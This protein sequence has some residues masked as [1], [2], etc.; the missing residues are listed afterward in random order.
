MFNVRI[1]KYVIVV[2]ALFV[3]FTLFA[4]NNAELLETKIENLNFKDAT[5]STIIESISNLTG[6]NI[7]LANES[8]KSSGSEDG[9]GVS[10]KRISVRL[11][12]I[13]VENAVSLVAKASG[14]TYN[15]MSN[16]T[17][18]IGPKNIVEQ[19][20]GT[21]NFVYQ[22]KYI[23][24][25]KIKKA[26]KDFPGEITEIAG[27]NAL[28]IRANPETYNDIK[29][30]LEK[31]DAQTKQVQVRVRVI[32]VNVT[33]TKK[34]GIDWSRL[35]SLST[36]LAENPVNGAGVGLPYNYSDV[37]GRLPI[38]DMTDIGVKPEQQYFQKM[39]NWDDFGNFSRQL[40]AFDVTL[41]WLLENNSAKI[42]TDTRLS[43]QNGETAK[44][45]IGE[46]IPYV[47]VDND[48]EVQVE[49]VDAG[50][51]LEITP[52]AN[53]D[54]EIT[55]RVRPEISSIT[56]LVGGYAPRLK[57]RTVE[58]TVTV[59]SGQTFVVSGLLSSQ[60]N[61][62]VNKVPFLGDIPFIGGLFRHTFEQV[63]KTD[64]IIEMTP[65]IVSTSDVY[66]EPQIEDILTERLIKFGEETEA[67]EK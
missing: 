49:K 22:L 63:E 50:I 15:V 4:Q 46:T 26:F 42:L 39:S 54:N 41:D 66:E 12:D 58:S 31:L 28:L 29:T 61:K 20:S 17:F 37:T 35:N 53:C 23:D 5:V 47:V 25:S 19:E 30:Q 10:A 24:S 3:S 64:L 1:K 57:V 60:K 16:N 43:A 33:D 62:R 32:E 21:R 51:K 14:F 44:V 56:D 59:P 18:L 40:Y 36:I 38:G 11:H 6:V 8:G 52:K 7:V 27:K 55:T 67:N 13:S 34:V 9:S 65:T 45:H 2:L 48:K